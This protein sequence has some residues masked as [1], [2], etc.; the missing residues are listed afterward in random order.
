MRD[1]SIESKLATEE[2]TEK[3]FRRLEQRDASTKALFQIA[4]REDTIRQQTRDRHL[5]RAVKS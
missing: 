5:W 4:T 3:M 2:A 1:E